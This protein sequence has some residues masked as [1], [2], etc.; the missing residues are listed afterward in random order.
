MED[1]K[2]NAPPITE[3]MK[4]DDARTWRE[5]WPGKVVISA[6]GTSATGCKSLVLG[7]GKDIRVASE[8][9]NQLFEQNEGLATVSY[10]VVGNNIH[11]LYTKQVAPEEMERFNRVERKVHEIIEQ[12]DAEAEKAKA[13]QEAAQ[14]ALDKAVKKKEEE[15]RKEN[16]RLMELG[17]VHEKNCSKKG[18]GK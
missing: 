1:L 18:K 17:R 7:D 2:L 9:F 5:W 4:A 13:A 16:N 3:S 15:Q 12:E 6:R 11:L 14:A 8:Q 10:E